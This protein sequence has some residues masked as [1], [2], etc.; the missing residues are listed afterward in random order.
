MG[1]IIQTHQGLKKKE[2][3]EGE[4]VSL[5][6]DKGQSRK[7]FSSLKKD[8]FGDEDGAMAAGSRLR[9]AEHVRSLYR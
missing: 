4:T 1:E 6:R 5:F 2:S 9:L 8:G 7:R 3:R